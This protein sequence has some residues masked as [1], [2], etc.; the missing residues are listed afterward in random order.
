MVLTVMASVAEFEA[1]RISERTKEALAAA[2]QRG[3]KLGGVRPGTIKSNTAAKAKADGEAELL[4]PILE[5][6]AAKGAS[7]REM[8]SALAG[9][10]RTTRNGQMLSAT[11]VKRLIARLGL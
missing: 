9:A 4:R 1:R 11:Q 7:L 5:A 3:V 6:M 10:G 2:K 8:A